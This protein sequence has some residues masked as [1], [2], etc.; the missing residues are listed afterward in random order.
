MWAAG[1]LI[2][3]LG[4]IVAFK[5]VLYLLKEEQFSENVLIV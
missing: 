2:H 4:K 1:I 5:T 3:A